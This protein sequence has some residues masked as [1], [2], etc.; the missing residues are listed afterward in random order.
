MTSLVDVVF[1]LLF[2]FMLASRSGP[3]RA[4]DVQLASAVSPAAGARVARRLDLRP[5]GV[6]VLDGEALALAQL[7]QRLRA[8]AAGPVL[9]QAHSGVSVQ[10]LVSLLDELR[11]LGTDVQLAG[12][13]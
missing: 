5:G 4:L 1:I 9:L 7:R 11:A 2:F 13:P 6:L 3:L 12:A 8:R 10:A